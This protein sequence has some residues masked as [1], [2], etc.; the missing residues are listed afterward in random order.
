M[1]HAMWKVEDLYVQDK[2]RRSLCRSLI[3][4]LAAIPATDGQVGTGP[5][6]D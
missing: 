3:E 6:L 2:G 4:K 5:L 1:M